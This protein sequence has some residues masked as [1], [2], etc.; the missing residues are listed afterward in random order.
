MPIFIK[1]GGMPAD[2][3]ATL[4]RSRAGSN[5][6][7]SYTFDHDYDIAIVTVGGYGTI[8]MTTGSGW[9][10]TH[11]DNVSSNRAVG[12]VKYNVQHGESVAVKCNDRYGIAIY[13]ITA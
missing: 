3:Q 8:S 2:P 6:T 11:S 10:Q 9:T 1:G 13:G 12:W 5:Q 7:T 4:L